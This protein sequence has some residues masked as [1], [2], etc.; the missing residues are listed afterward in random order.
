MNQ[1][2]EYFFELRSHREYSLEDIASRAGCHKTLVWKV[3]NSKSVN[4]DSLKNIALSGL[5]LSTDSKEYRKLVSLWVVAQ[6]LMDVP[7]AV[8]TEIGRVAK[9]KNRTIQKIIAKLIPALDR[10][11]KFEAESLVQALADDESRGAV[12]ALSQYYSINLKPDT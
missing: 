6:G 5:G 10:M 1:L 4:A 11:S 8:H 2:A 9:S 12:L 3:E 7:P